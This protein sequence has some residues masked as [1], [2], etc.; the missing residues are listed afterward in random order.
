MQEFS[1][2]LGS[3]RVFYLPLE[4]GKISFVDLRDVV[5]VT[6]TILISSSS[7]LKKY[8]GKVSLRNTSINI[9]II[10]NKQTFPKDLHFNWSGA[11]HLSGDRYFV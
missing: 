3:K 1:N 6:A 9:I 5:D 4:N 10:I 2:F 11:H 8:E 7:A